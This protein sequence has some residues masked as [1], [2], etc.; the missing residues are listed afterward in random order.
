MTLY[1]AIDVW[2]RR[3]SETVIRYRCFQSLTNNKF[4]VQSSDFIRDGAAIDSLDKQ[5]EELLTQQD[6]AERSGEYDSLEAAIAA[7]KRDFGDSG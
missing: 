5:F 1:K 7:H 6:P 2:E 4:C 3:D